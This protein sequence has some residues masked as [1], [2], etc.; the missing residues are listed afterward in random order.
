MNI[1]FID[2]D[3]IKQNSL[4]DQN[5]DDKI[6]E[7]SI[8]RAQDIQILELVGTDLY[9][10]LQDLIDSNSVS[11]YYQTLL[12][13]YISKALIEWTVYY[14]Y[15]DGTYKFTNKSVVKRTTESS[16][17]VDDSTI[18]E[19]R[20]HQKSTAEFYSN[21]VIQ[22]LINNQVEFPEWLSYSKVMGFLGQRNRKY[23][24][25][26]IYLGNG[27]NY[28]SDRNLNKNKY[29]GSYLNNNRNI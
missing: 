25:T 28:T 12:D 24:S 11:G 17:N 20:R 4:L 16:T 2:V 14:I 19:L 26:G 10:K 22:F 5:I 27:L 29:G 21:R 13:V 3:T 18:R 7:F 8:D 6:I 9:K 1:G 15:T 23:S